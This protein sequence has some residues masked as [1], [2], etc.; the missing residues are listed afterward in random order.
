MATVIL[1]RD[2]FSRSTLVSL[3]REVDY[4]PVYAGT[5]ARKVR[6]FLNRYQ[7]QIKLIVLSGEPDEHLRN[8]LE[9]ISKNDSL[10]LAP[11]IMM[12]D[13][14]KKCKDLSSQV[15]GWLAKPFGISKMMQAIQLAHANRSNR[16]DT[17]LVLSKN[18]Q[19]RHQVS[20][21]HWK[22]VLMVD[23]PEAFLEKAQELGA[24]IGAMA[25]DPRLC[26]HAFSTWISQFKKSAL[27]AITP[28]A[29]LSQVAEDVRPFRSTGDLFLHEDQWENISSGLSL[30]TLHSWNARR[31]ITEGRKL[32]KQ[33]LYGDSMR[34]IE[35]G[36][37]QNPRRWEFHELAGILAAKRG[38]TS[39]AIEHFRNALNENPCA[40]SSYLNLLN[41]VGDEDKQQILK[42]GATYCPAHPQLKNLIRLHQSE[43]QAA[44]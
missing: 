24:G 9:D 28:L 21:S 12:S 25:V 29:I 20:E 37:A 6:Y 22:T 43:L 35:A 15:D 4:G 16:R 34:M 30:R 36:L 31:V 41:L 2:E 19:L 33:G 14:G 10:R 27:G 13:T 11:V 23:S 1:E 32:I 17:L 5:T 42:A 38:L 26:G 40:P 44:A 8:L 18:A 3:L 39:R 7:T